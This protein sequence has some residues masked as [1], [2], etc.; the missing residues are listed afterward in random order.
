MVKEERAAA[1][2]GPG[3]RRGWKGRARRE[4]PT[5]LSFSFSNRPPRPIPRGARRPWATPRPCRPGGAKEEE[6]REAPRPAGARRLPF[7]ERKRGSATGVAG[8]A[9]PVSARPRPRTDPERGRPPGRRTAQR[10]SGAARD[11]EPP[12]PGFSSRAS[13]ARRGSV[14]ARV[15]EGGHRAKGGRC[16]QRLCLTRTRA[17]TNTNRGEGGGP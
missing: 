12:A 10:T 16:C 8:P 13:G 14:C 4:K 15:C 5:P 9:Q 3:G 17:L 2:L 1:A 11:P 6:G 7:A